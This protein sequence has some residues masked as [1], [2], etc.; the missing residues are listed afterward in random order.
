MKKQ[1]F[2]LIELLVVVAIIGVLAAI[3]MVSFGYVRTRAKV[4]TTKSLLQSIAQA[5][6]NYMADENV[7]PAADGGSVQDMDKEFERKTDE[8]G[9]FKN[10]QALADA[11]CLEAGEPGAGRNGPYFNLKGFYKLR[12]KSKAGVRVSGGQCRSAG[13]GKVEIVDAFRGGDKKVGQAI[14]YRSKWR[15][16]NGQ[17]QRSTLPVDYQLLSI[18]PD[19]QFNNGKGD[20]ILW[21]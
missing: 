20:D 3:L 11:L 19:G 18:G 21:E 14:R 13:N 7:P 17:Y 5:L 15:L 2:T 8:V 16:V 1:G 12:N 4:S 9:V 10:N 6:S